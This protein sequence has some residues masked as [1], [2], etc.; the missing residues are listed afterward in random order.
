MI[1]LLINQPKTWI[2]GWIQD[3]C[4]G[5][6]H[7]WIGISCIW[8]FH[9]PCGRKYL[10]LSIWVKTR[11]WTADLSELHPI[12]PTYLK[13]VPALIRSLI[14]KIIIPGIW[15]PCQVNENWLRVM[16]RSNLRIGIQ[17][18]A[19]VWIC[20]ATNYFWEGGIVLEKWRQMVSELVEEANRW[21]ALA[22]D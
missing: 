1:P 21:H 7:L 5:L 16:L 19:E 4:L 8:Q 14:I 12:Y 3:M 17:L 18:I 13:R 20:D 15:K 2:P 6:F 10:Q 11:L 22:H 9:F